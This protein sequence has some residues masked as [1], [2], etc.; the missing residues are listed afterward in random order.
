MQFVIDKI[1]EDAFYG[2]MLL[3][4]PETL[5]I[6]GI[7]DT[8]IARKQGVPESDVMQWEFKN[9][10]RL[11]DDIKNFYAATDGF[12]YTWQSSEP[13]D[14][15]GNNEGVVVSGRIEVNPISQ[16]THLSGLVEYHTKANTS[17][18]GQELILG[19]ESKVFELCKIDELGKVSNFF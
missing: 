1:S 7:H 6:L 4:L 8:Y 9:G 17:G 19:I 12:L 2:N 14:N 18:G 13:E 3:G 5:S 15:N 10:I 16:F 11:A